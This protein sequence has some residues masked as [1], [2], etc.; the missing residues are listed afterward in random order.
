MQH[1]AYVP[2]CPN[3]VAKHMQNVA[4]CCVGMLWS[5][6][7]GIRVSRSKVMLLPPGWDGSHLCWSI[8]GLTNSTHPS[9]G[10][11]WLSCPNSLL[12]TLTDRCEPSQL[13]SRP[14]CL[15]LTKAF[16]ERERF[17]PY[18]LIFQHLGDF[19]TP[20]SSVQMKIKLTN[21]SSRVTTDLHSRGGHKN[22]LA[23]IE[24]VCTFK[25]GVNCL[26]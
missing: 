17:F 9:P 11:I 24:S 6:G 23:W 14:L 15:P 22:T 20:L 18:V 12:V 7:R 25:L 5:F 2:T 4:I 26:M 13:I 19:M 8:T 16:I 10:D 21:A 1:V 3:T